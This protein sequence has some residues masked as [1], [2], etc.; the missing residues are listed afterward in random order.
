MS[1]TSQ[2]QAMATDEVA[3]STGGSSWQVNDLNR[4]HRF[5]CYGTEGNVYHV[6]DKEF[7]VEQVQSVCRLIESGHGED[8]VREIVAFATEGKAAKQE[9]V[10][11]ALAVCARTTTDLKTKQ[12]AYKGLGQVCHNP[13]HLFH[14]VN[15]AERLSGEHTG[16][17]RAQRKAIKEWYNSKEPQQLALAV[18]KYKQRSGWSHTDLLRLAHVKPTKDSK[19]DYYN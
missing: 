13:V 7:N 2:L 18:T 12:A 11:F 8:A 6:S 9:S 3:N 16:W 19:Y 1:G 17:G 5:L 14:F 10:I 15:F 4:L